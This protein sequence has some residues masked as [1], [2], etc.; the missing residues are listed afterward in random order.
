MGTIFVCVLLG[1]QTC[2]QHNDLETK[3]AEEQQSLISQDQPAVNEQDKEG[4]IWNL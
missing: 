4:M 2:T 1:F 3:I